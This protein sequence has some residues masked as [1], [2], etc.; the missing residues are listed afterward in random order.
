MTSWVGFSQRRRRAG[1]RANSLLA[2][3]RSD[4]L[5]FV[6]QLSYHSRAEG[7]IELLKTR[8]I[9]GRHVL[10]SSSYAAGS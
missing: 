9:S 10:Q 1:R 4:V 7:S 2:A 5:D 8:L 3:P 6:A